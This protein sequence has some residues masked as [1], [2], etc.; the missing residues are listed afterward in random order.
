[1]CSSERPSTNFMTKKCRSSICR[2][3]W[4]VMMCGWLMF[5]TV[6]ASCRKRRTI[7]SPVSS[8]G[9]ITLIATLRLSATSCARYTAAMPP[10]PSSRRTSNSPAV[11]ARSRPATWIQGFASSPEAWFAATMPLSVPG[12]GAGAAA[13]AEPIGG[14]ERGAATFTAGNGGSC[15]AKGAEA[16]AGPEYARRIGRT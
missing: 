3:A 5:A 8:A 4:M 10:R 15:S 6:T 11:A 12:T 7:P 9:D 1:M 16:I 13:R 14:A 2:T